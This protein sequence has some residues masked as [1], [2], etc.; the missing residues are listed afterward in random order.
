VDV[1]YPIINKN[2]LIITEVNIALTRE[3]GRERGREMF[4]LC[5]GEIKIK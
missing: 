2:V 3:R 1:I 4:Y 5:G